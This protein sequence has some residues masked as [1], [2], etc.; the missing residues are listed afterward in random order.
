MWRFW[1]RVRAGAWF[2][3]PTP[4]RDGVHNIST[5][6]DI[7]LRSRP[8]LTMAFTYR[9]TALDVP[10]LLLAYHN[11]SITIE[12]SEL[13]HKPDNLTTTHQMLRNTLFRNTTKPPLSAP[14]RCLLARPNAN[15]NVPRAG[16]RRIATGKKAPA[17]P[18]PSPRSNPGHGKNP[19]EDPANDLGGPGGQELYPAS[20][21]LQR[22][23]WIFLLSSSSSP[24]TA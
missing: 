18:G 6:T 11:L 22:C 15:V 13:P 9:S 5:A 12:T 16:A 14:S 20:G 23:A 8:A 7:R 19:L 24:P 2:R 4:D 21:A 17:P 1:G 10:R 3:G